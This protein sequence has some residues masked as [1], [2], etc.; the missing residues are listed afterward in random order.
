MMLFSS[1]ISSFFTLVGLYFSYSFDIT[2]GASIILVSAGFL[3]LFL[4]I[5]K[6][7]SII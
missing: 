5:E 1:L 4:L 2:S 7:R 3:I 6:V